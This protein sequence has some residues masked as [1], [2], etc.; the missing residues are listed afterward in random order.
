[1]GWGRMLLLGNG[2]EVSD[3]VLERAVKLKTIGYLGN[4]RP[5]LSHDIATEMGIVIFDDIRN[6]PRNAKFI[7]K[8]MAD[9]I[10]KGDTHL[11][12]NFPNLQLPKVKKAHRLIHIHSNLPGIMA[13]INQ[14]Y[15]RHNINILGQFLRTNPQI[16]YVITDVSAQYDQ[17]VLK[18]LKQIDHTIKFRVLY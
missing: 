10:N 14:V 1:M 6:N 3:A 13:Q 8:R 15:A 11:S 18:E 2:Q 7:P 9:F 12:S 16:G 4:S 5:N 17:E